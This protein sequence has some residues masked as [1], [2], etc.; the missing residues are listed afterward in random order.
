MPLLSVV[1]PCYNE[2]ATV[3]AIVDKVRNAPFPGER[4]I[5]VVDDDSTD[6]TREIL[7]DRLEALVDQVVYHDSNRG[8]G[9]ALRSGLEFATGDLIVIQ[10]ADL[11]YDPREFEKLASPILSGDADVVYGSRF[12]SGQARAGVRLWHRMGNRMLTLLSNLFTNLTLTDMETCYK[13][14]RK[15]ALHGIVLEEDRFGVDPE[16]TAKFARRRWR[17]REVGIAYAGRRYS[18]GKKIGWRDGC[19]A[20]YCIVK[21]SLFR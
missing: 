21:Y 3:A 4:Q 13:M 16:I 12:A 14:F 6:G 15:E 7:R 19:R 17:I 11:E 10:D 8:K 18:E 2:R 9:A 1:I 20:V 5:I